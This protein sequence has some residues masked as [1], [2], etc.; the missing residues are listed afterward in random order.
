MS[1]DA[2][3]RSSTGTT[4]ADILSVSF[5]DLLKDTNSRMSSNVS[6]L[7]ARVD[8]TVSARQ[9]EKSVESPAAA[10]RAEDTH[11]NRSE[12]HEYRRDR[13]ERR[14]TER[15]EETARHRHR[16]RD[17]NVRDDDKTAET[18]PTDDSRPTEK[19]SETEQAAESAHKDDADAPTS[20]DT[21]ASGAETAAPAK[22]QAETAIAGAVA[23]STAAT[24]GAETATDAKQ[25]GE[26]VAAANAAAG[27]QTANAGPATA[28]ANPNGT[29]Q[30]Q[31]AVAAAAAVN[32]AT[33]DAKSAAQTPHG[34]AQAT[35]QNAATNPELQALAQSQANGQMKGA[36]TKAQQAATL[37]RMVGNG[38][39]TTV[40]TTVDSDADTLVSRPT[41]ALSSMAVAA[42]TAKPT[43]TPAQPTANGANAMAG[44]A[45][46]QAGQ[47]A[48][49][50]QQG[51]AQA[52][53]GQIGANGDASARATASLTA[54]GAATTATPTTGTG[55]GFAATLNQATTAT[56]TAQQTAR[57]Q[58]ANA[59]KANLPRHAVVSQVTV[60][61]SK[62]AHTGTDRI[63][64]QLRPEELGRVD[65]KMEVG[66]DGRVNAVVTADNKDTLAM[67][68]RDSRELE[69]ALQQ[70]GLQT[71]SGS[72]SFNLRGENNEGQDAESGLASGPGTSNAEADMMAEA[73]ESPAIAA[74]EGGI[75]PD[76]R[77]DIRA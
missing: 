34:A 52:A 3:T 23:N 74:Y 66:H 18:A 40:N 39:Q 1:Q 15:T 29:A 13:S 73:E 27:P 69:R 26:A 21:A 35:Q 2:G 22:D 33:G 72:L 58:T 36:D 62:A 57:A 16:D 63:N 19:T 24:T 5:S 31:A 37:S 59:D 53:Q 51:M 49:Q 42:E 56:N 17:D 55:E 70:A 10:D 71:D 28:N 11:A 77:V 14:G 6:S 30:T 67:L 4:A 20:D 50:A 65:V 46:V 64:I 75:R 9:P 44:Q 48:G 68:Q 8:R 60:Q 45:A 38:N 32:A 76:G 43:Q 7:V 41:T 54:T 25:P 12:S 47:T 61:I